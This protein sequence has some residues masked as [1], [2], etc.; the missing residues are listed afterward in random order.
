MVKKIFTLFIL[1]LCLIIG[2]YFFA[3]KA[4]SPEL[5]L[6]CCAFCDPKVLDNQKFYEDELVIALCTYRPILP[7]HSLVIPKR[8]VER[9]EWLTD[10]ETLQIDKVI[11][12]VNEATS[13]VYGTSAYLLVQKNG[14]EVGQSV[15][16]VHFHYIPRKA[17]D[18]SMI[19]FFISMFLANA[20]P[21]LSAKETH[22]TAKKMKLAMQSQPK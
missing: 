20:K 12:K 21:H 15:P 14:H 6:N 3:L 18:A 19:K 4:F 17:R 5:P 1:L 8:H 7:G 11:K 2:L 13:R 10:E 16:H 22:E 9:F